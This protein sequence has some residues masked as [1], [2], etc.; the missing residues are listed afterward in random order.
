[1]VG[2]R[3]KGGEGELGVGG[4]Y[5]AKANVRRLKRLK[6]RNKLRIE[7]RKASIRGRIR[8]FPTRIPVSN[9][10]RKELGGDT[11]FID[12]EHVIDN[13]KDALDGL[14]PMIRNMK[15]VPSDRP[16]DPMYRAIDCPRC[17]CPCDCGATTCNSTVKKATQLGL[18][19][20]EDVDNRGSCRACCQG[21]RTK[22]GVEM[23]QEQ[24][25]TWNVDF[26]LQVDRCTERC[27]F[28][29][30]VKNIQVEIEN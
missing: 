20:A 30:L 5:N 12:I 21:D 24:C 3:D 4:R 26:D 2:A 27:L 28:G 9:V 13:V 7:I 23:E 15:V 11:D 8:K 17:N 18:I 10:G 19:S 25:F 29:G 14:I 1:M 22:I 6:A 16:R